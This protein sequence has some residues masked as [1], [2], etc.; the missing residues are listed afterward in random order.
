M[1]LSGDQRANR[2]L[3]AGSRASD[4][5]AIDNL[6]AADAVLGA[7]PLQR[8]ELLDLVLVVR[9]DE[10]AAADV[11]DAVARR[12]TRTSARGPRRTAAP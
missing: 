12:R 10:L 4:E 8:F 3:T 6:E 9:D 11:R 5:R 2:V 1:P 7:A